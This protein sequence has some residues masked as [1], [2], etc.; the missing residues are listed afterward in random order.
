MKDSTR[1]GSAER[2]GRAGVKLVE[3][4]A[5][6]ASVVAAREKRMAYFILFVGQKIRGGYEGTTND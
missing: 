6:A 5:G 1:R 4:M 2:E 3:G